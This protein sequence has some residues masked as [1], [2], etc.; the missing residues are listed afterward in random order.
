MQASGRTRLQLPSWHPCPYQ[1]LLLQ[2]A[3]LSQHKWCF[4]QAG[5][6]KKQC[7]QLSH[8]KPFFRFSPTPTALRHILVCVMFSV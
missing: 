7:L 3:W 2:Q 6:A 4:L 5:R 1:R 8:P